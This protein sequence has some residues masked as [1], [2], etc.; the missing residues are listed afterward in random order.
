MVRRQARQIPDV[1]VAP[2]QE[3]GAVAPRKE[4]ASERRM[5]GG[6]DKPGQY[7]DVKQCSEN[8]LPSVEWE[9]YYLQVIYVNVLCGAWCQVQAA[10]GM[11]TG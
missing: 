9:S 5:E 3:G 10:D 6:G 11:P 8:L 4:G 2:K 1:V 7:M